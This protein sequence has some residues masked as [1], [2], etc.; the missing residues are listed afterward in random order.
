MV[1]KQ[2]SVVHVATW[3]KLSEINAKIGQLLADGKLEP[4]SMPEENRRCMEW[5]LNE[6]GK[7]GWEFK[8]QLVAYGS[9]Y[10]IFCK[11]GDPT[12]SLD[13]MLKKVT[14]DVEPEEVEGAEPEEEFQQL[15]EIDEVSKNA[16]PQKP[17][18][19]R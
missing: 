6:M 13:D 10:F 7:E 12:S 2:H 3:N 18:K 9:T 17:P 8:A 19:N 5:A 4:M 1:K 11:E 15:K 16:K 14:P